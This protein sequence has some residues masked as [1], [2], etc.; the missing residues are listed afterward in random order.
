MWFDSHCHLNDEA[1]KEDLRAVIDETLQAGVSGMMVVGY[2]LPSS[3]R[4]I[5]LAAAYNMIW[6]AVGLHPHDAKDWALRCATNWN[7][8]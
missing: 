4:A 7:N 1:F 2:D 6:A 5:E 3:I 8:S